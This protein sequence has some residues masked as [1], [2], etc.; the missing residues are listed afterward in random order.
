[1]KLVKILS[2]LMVLGAFVGCGEKTNE[3]K[4]KDAIDNAAD[5]AKD[6]AD[7]T[8]DAAKDLLGGEKK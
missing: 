7:K 5:K 6:A 2:V 1:M 8:A 4:A 3:E